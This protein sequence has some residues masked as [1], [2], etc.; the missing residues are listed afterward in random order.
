MPHVLTKKKKKKFLKCCLLLIYAIAMNIS[1]SDCDVQQK[2][3]CVRQ[4]VMTNSGVGPRRSSKALPKENLHQKKVMFTV[5][6]PAAHLIHYSFLNF[7]ET[8]TSEKYAQQID[9]M[10]W[11]CNAYHRHWSTEGILILLHGNAQ[12]HI[13]RP[14][15]QKL[16]ELG[17]K[18]LPH[19]PYSPDL[20]PT[21]YH[22]FKHLNN[23]LQRK[24]FQNKQDEEN[25][26]QEVTESQSVDFYATGINKLISHWQ[27]CVD[28]NSSYFD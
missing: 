14:T 6:W 1:W 7:D 2:V 3:D 4:S 16:N 18:V 8:I 27:K 28:C 19:L 10:H 25:A 17:Y 24:H 23:F 15:L 11:N 12:Q 9:A 13:A 5:W 26:F 20:L 22:F 21:D